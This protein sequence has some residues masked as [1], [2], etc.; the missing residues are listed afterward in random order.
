M[1]NDVLKEFS[2]G[3]NS[4][5][6][7]PSIVVKKEG[8]P[9]KF[10]SGA[11][12]FIFEGS[13]GYSKYT[14]FK[15]MLTENDKKRLEERGYKDVTPKDITKA[16]LDNVIAN[17]LE[18]TR[19]KS[20]EKLVAS[21]PQIWFSNSKLLDC[22]KILQDIFVQNP[23]VK[24]VQL[25]SEPA[26]ACAFFVENYKKNTGKDFLGKILLVDY[27]G[28]TLDIALC[29]VKQAGD[30]SEVSVKHQTGAGENQEGVIGKAGLAFQ[31]GVVK[32]A[33]AKRG[34]SEEEI[35]NNREFH[36]CMLHFE[37]D[38]ISHS[39][40]VKG[41]F[42][43]EEH[44][45]EA[46]TDPFCDIEMNGEECQ[47]T[48]GMMAEV[49]NEMISPILKEKI[50]D[51]KT[52]MDKAGIDYKVKDRDDF[53]I[54]LVGGFCNFYLTQKQVEDL[55][56]WVTEED[57]RFKDIIRD[58]RECEKA[59]SYGA[60][61]IAGG[62]IGFRQTAPYS[63]GIASERGDMYFAVHF[64]QDIIPGKPYTDN[65]IFVGNK[66]PKI[67]F[68]FSR[69][70]D[71]AQAAEPLEKYKEALKLKPGKGIKLA[72]SF[73]ESMMITLHKYVV[74]DIYSPNPKTVDEAAVLIDDIHELLG[75]IEVGGGKS[76]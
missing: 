15:M 1:E 47:I 66:I 43:M 74:D 72:F 6:L 73:D 46:I 9:L 48:F 17:Y 31:E 27:G 42:D 29:D 3:Q 65:R 70:E 54:A 55:F 26:A 7:Q 44:D 51:V 57:L 62:K 76:V 53:K 37:D 50:E 58:R 63:L 21:V 13:S 16:Y 59:I 28:G 33:L 35:V 56:D 49:Y 69:N 60:A 39:A 14:G 19:Q 45:M 24:E 34:L 11:V 38:L 52:Y 12:K 67:A 22:R 2:P 10:G 41:N 25:V 8:K 64:G 5:P 68:N 18:V 32:L 40:E 30:R 61:L 36:K 4:S 20:I 71:N 75:I 23:V